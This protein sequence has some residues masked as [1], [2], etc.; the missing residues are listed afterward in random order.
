MHSDPSSCEADSAGPAKVLALGYVVSDLHIFA[1]WSS[2][3]SYMGDIRSA[4]ADAD[5]FVFNGDIFDFKWS[6]LGSSAKTTTAAI[7]WLHKLC[8]DFPQCHFFY[9]LG[10][11]DCHVSLR[12]RLTTLTNDVG[13]FSWNGSHF[14][15]GTSLFMHGDLIFTTKG[16]SPF[17]RNKFRTGQ[18]RHSLLGSGYHVAIGMGAHNVASRMFAKEKCAKQL[19]KV[20]RQREYS[21][22]DGVEDIYI[23]HTHTS[24]SDFKYRGLTF[25]NSGSAVHDLH[26]NMLQV[27]SRG[28]L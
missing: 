4:A 5:F 16:L 25:H 23:G 8:S 27:G 7:D 28:S 18:P 9:V 20:L 13:N 10:N 19:L 24:F 2:A 22:M 15:I 21:E 6:T 11:H 3:E 1:K 12:D 17:A 14:R 26:C